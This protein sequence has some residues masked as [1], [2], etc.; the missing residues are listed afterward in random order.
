MIDEN[1]N[2]DDDVVAEDVY[3]KTN[4]KKR[5][6]TECLTLGG[7]ERRRRLT[8]AQMPEN[9]VEGVVEIEVQHQELLEEVNIEIRPARHNNYLIGRTGISATDENN[10]PV[11][12]GAMNRICRHCNA[13]YF[14]EELNT[15]GL[16]LKCCENGN[17]L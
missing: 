1:C 17:Y 4:T 7:E 3:N 10:P 15:S 9:R 14:R 8:L 11:I 13:L 5:R 12:I 6:K 2:V 16:Y